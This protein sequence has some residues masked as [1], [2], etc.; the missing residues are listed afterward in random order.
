MAKPV[1]VLLVTL[2]ALAPATS[3]PQE[4]PN[5]SEGYSGPRSTTP[6]GSPKD[7]FALSLTAKSTVVHLGS[8]IWVT[9]EVRNL[10]GKAQPFQYGSRHSSYTFRIVNTKT[11]TA[12]APRENGF[13]LASISGP[14]GRLVA[15]TLSLYGDFRLDLLYNITEPGNYSIQVTNGMPILNGQDLQLISNA[16]NMTILP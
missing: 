12:A 6:L 9:V 3:I 13:G 11:K 15:P 7:G 1:A 4:Q 8:P 2:W 5:S 10:T 16:I 14:F